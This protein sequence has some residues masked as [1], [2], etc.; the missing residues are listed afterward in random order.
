MPVVSERVRA[1]SPLRR[2]GEGY[3][4]R[5]LASDS[6]RDRVTATL[7]EHYVRGRLTAE[8]LADR[9]E[10]VVRARSRRELR[11]AL[12]GLPMLPDGR[13]LAAHGRSAARLALRGA[14]LVLFTG[15]YL[16]FC[17]ALLLVL[18][19]TVLVQGASASALV[20]FLLVWLVP[21]F[22]LYRLWYRRPPHRRLST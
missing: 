1:N 16:M 18:A 7:R 19:V 17:F 9:A 20:A 11:R 22:L 10:L 4:G 12:S 3:D 15:A 2:A 5:V 14:M 13:E 21:T 6:D 8:E